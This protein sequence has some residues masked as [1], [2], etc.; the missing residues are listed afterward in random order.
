LG[1]R[2]AGVEFD[3]EKR[4]GKYYPKKLKPNRLS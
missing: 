4:E 1:K 2:R 3:A